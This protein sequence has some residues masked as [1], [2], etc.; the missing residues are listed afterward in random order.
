MRLDLDVG[1]PVLRQ[2]LTLFP[3][4]S[5][6]PAAPAYLTGPQAE[7]LGVLRVAED[8]QGPRVGALTVHNAG[9]LPLLLVQGETLLGAKQNR[10]IGL[11]V[12]VPAG[13]PVTVGVHCVEAGRWGPPRAARRSSRHAPL[14]LR[15][16]TVRGAARAEAPA[17]IQDSV[18]GSIAAYEQVLTCFSPSSALEDLHA[19]QAA[20]TNALVHGLTPA[21]AQCGVAVAVGGTV[22][23]L[24][25]FDKP[26]TLASYWDSLLAGYALD[27]LT[28][29]AA[30]AAAGAG[31][32]VSTKATLRA[33]LLDDVHR[34]L[35]RLLDAP[36]TEVAN[37]GLG[38]RSVVSGDGVVASVLEW[39]GA[40]VHCSAFATADGGRTR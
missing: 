10:Q 1:T 16:V 17:R 25:L 37:P 11:S 5:R 32:A 18:W 20:E 30:S 21:P 2:E 27:A 14:G 8:P 23:A 29:R 4:F 34:F 36:A 38:T 31:R 6:S 26:E 12:L 3:L 22:S 19:S 40:V 24:D 15:Q 33:T 28:T 39:G 13:A 35:H 7:R 9:V